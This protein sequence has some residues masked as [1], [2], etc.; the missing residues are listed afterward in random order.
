METTELSNSPQCMDQINPGNLESFCD[1]VSTSGDKG[2][3]THVIYLN[4]C[5]AFATVPQHLS[6]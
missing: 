4:F 6:L 5:K 1:G 2:R 3:T